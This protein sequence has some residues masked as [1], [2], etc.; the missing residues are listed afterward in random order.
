MLIHCGSKLRVP[1][2]AVRV[3]MPPALSSDTSACPRVCLEPVGVLCQVLEAR[4][5]SVGRIRRK[6]II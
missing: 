3:E 5:N 4:K 2:N 6:R 1:P